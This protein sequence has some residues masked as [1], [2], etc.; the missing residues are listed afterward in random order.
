[1]IHSERVNLPQTPANIPWQIYTRRPYTLTRLETGKKKKKI[2]TFLRYR[3][4]HWRWQ[5]RTE[6]R[7]N[8]GLLRKHE[9]GRKKNEIII[10]RSQRQV[11]LHPSPGH[12]P[13]PVSRLPCVWADLRH[14][15]HCIISLAS[16]FRFPLPRRRRRIFVPLLLLLP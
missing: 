8:V 6:I 10:K 16:S 11:L 13:G 7:N 4:T 14:R 15:T 2:E 5:F 3:D 9:G 1:M 12:S